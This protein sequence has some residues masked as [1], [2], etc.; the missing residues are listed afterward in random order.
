MAGGIDWFRWHHGSVTDPKFQLV[1]KKAGSRFGDVVAVWAFILEAASTA[2]DRGCIGPV[3]VESLDFMLGAEDGTTSR[4]LGAMTSR[5]LI[6]GTRIASW[7]R[8]QPK[9]EREDDSSTERVR[10]FRQK[11]RQQQE[12]NAKPGNETPGNATERQETPRVEESREEVNTSTSLRSVERPPKRGTR[13]APDDFRPDADLS[14]WARDN[15][16]V[17][18][19]QLETEKF[20]DHTFK[21]AITDWDGAWRNWIRRAGENPFTGGKPTASETPYQRSMRERMTEFAGPS[22][23]APPGPPTAEV[24]DVTARRLG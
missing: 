15:F 21:T 16:P 13:K 11:Q 3:D 1:A 20:R 12:C 4:I 10:A 17:V 5:G 24:I 22:A 14:A 19:A 18:N 2:A 9:R 8:R 6:E 7:E 23:K